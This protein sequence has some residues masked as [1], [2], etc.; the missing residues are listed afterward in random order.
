MG[1]SHKGANSPII[2]PHFFGE[3]EGKGKVG[4]C[5]DAG[6]VYRWASVGGDGM[7]S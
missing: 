4:G 2:V 5:E 3:L 6:R 1:I 7:A